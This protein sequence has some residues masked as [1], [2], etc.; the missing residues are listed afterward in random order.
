MGLV[1]GVDEV[2]AG[3]AEE[4]RGREPHDVDDPVVHERKLAIE[5]VPGYKLV[6]ALRVV[7]VT[8]VGA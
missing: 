1:L 8:R 4:L 3:L 2:E 6:R 5:R 7:Q